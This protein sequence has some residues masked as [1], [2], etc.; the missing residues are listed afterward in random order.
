MQQIE[1]F[2]K[3]VKFRRTSHYT[4]LCQMLGGEYI[5]NIHMDDWRSQY[6][7]TNCQTFCYQGRI[8]TTMT[9]LRGTQEYKEAKKRLENLWE[10]TGEQ[11]NDETRRQFEHEFW[12]TLQLESKKTL[13]S[14]IALQDLMA[15]IIQNVR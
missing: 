6:Q 1:Y 9:T 11:W 5:F 7:V 13:A 12:S 15:Q 14:M 10:A 8:E 3:S 2:G 4:Y